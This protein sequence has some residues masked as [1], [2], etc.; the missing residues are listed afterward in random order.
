[1][2]SPARTCQ[3]SDCGKCHVSRRDAAE[4]IQSHPAS[5]PSRAVSCDVELG[6]VPDSMNFLCREHFVKVA[7]MRF[8]IL[9]IF[10]LCPM[11]RMGMQ[12][13]EILAVRFLP[14]SELS[15]HPGKLVAAIRIG[16]RLVA[17]R[18]HPAGFF[19]TICVSRARNCG[20]L[21]A[22]FSFRATP[23]VRRTCGRGLTSGFMPRSV[24]TMFVLHPLHQTDFRP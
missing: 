23:S 13:T 22:E 12:V 24:V 18:I 1:M 8:K 17:N 7:K 14:V 4:R 15:L 6:H 3:S 9:Q 5:R 20:F 10:P 19:C 2:A 11:V 16:K 21:A